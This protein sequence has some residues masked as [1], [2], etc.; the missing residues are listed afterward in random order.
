MRTSTQLNSKSVVSKDHGEEG[1]RDLEKL[2]SWSSWLKVGS[3]LSKCWGHLCIC[4]QVLK[5]T[6]FKGEGL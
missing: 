2:P 4:D 6:A 1:G 3:A 5:G